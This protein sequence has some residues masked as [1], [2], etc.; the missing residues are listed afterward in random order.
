MKVE[1]TIALACATAAQASDF[2][3]AVVAYAPAPGQQTSSP[4]FNTPA[5]ALYRSAGDVGFLLAP[6]LLGL[7]AGATSLSTSLVVGGVLVAIGGVV[8]VAGSQGDPAAG[9][10]VPAAS[11]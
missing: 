4:D 5:R 9:R 3:D 8:F 7:L 2:A 6:P 11:S 10:A 1:L